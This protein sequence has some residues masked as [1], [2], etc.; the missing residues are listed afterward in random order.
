MSGVS[1]ELRSSQSGDKIPQEKQQSVSK[2]Y[3]KTQEQLLGLK[4][5]IDAVDTKHDAKHER[6]ANAAKT[7]A[8][9]FE[10]RL[11]N[12][13]NDMWKMFEVSQSEISSF[14]EAEAE[15]RRRLADSLADEVEKAVKSTML[16]VHSPL[17][18][19]LSD[20]IKKQTEI[21]SQAT[22]SMSTADNFCTADVCPPGPEA[23]LESTKN[24]RD[25][26]KP[27]FSRAPAFP[28]HSSGPTAD[29]APTSFTRSQGCNATPP[30]DSCSSIPVT[31]G[32][33]MQVMQMP[34]SQQVN[35]VLAKSVQGQVRQHHPS[36]QVRPLPKQQ[37]QPQPAHTISV[38]V[39]SKPF[40]GSV[41]TRTI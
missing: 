13:T 41:D 5:F 1:D 2:D 26:D 32:A 25:R 22:A 24:S 27:P 34:T 18:Q 21:S 16:Q 19:Q 10:T 37:Q 11:Q 39:P 17:F 15:E 28:A 3:A 14:L 30:S 8:S 31:V 35:H 20:Q 12:H 9:G 36:A 38:H 23:F 4:R 7:S 6:V 33:P 29:L 40:L